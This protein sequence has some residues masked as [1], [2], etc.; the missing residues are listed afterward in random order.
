MPPRRLP[1]LAMYQGGLHPLAVDP[2]DPSL[3]RPRCLVP[4][5]D[6]IFPTRVLPWVVL[7]ISKLQPMTSTLHVEEKK[8]N[9]LQSLLL[10]SISF[11]STMLLSI[12]FE[13]Y[14]AEHDSIFFIF[15]LRL[16]IHWWVRACCCLQFLRA[17]SAHYHVPRNGCR[18]LLVIVAMQQRVS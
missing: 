12:G 5:E 10:F 7:L 13:K 11:L 16:C 4:L 2:E 1:I 15:L 3:P 18:P 17:V 6:A 9:S 14:K 8:S